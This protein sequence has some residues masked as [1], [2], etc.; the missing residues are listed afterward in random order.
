M[1]GNLAW[2]KGADADRAERGAVAQSR[3]KSRTRVVGKIRA[4]KT[5]VEIATQ[6][7]MIKQIG[8]VRGDLQF[9]SLPNCKSSSQAQVN[10]ETARPPEVADGRGGVPHPILIGDEASV[11]RLQ[12]LA[13]KRARAVLE[14]RVLSRR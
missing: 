10:I 1:H 8:S 11:C 12:H 3:Y 4:A 6:F 7:R 2:V 5:T 9:D 14:E 13:L